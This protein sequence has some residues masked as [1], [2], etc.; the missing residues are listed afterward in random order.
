MIVCVFSSAMVSRVSQQ[1]ALERSAASFAGVLDIHAAVERHLIVA[2]AA[3]VQA[4][5]RVADALDEQLFHVQC[6]YPPTSS[7][8]TVHLPARDI[9]RRLPLT[10]FD[11]SRPR[12][13]AD[14]D[15]LLA[16]HCRVRNTD[17]GDILIGIAACQTVMEEWKCI[18]QPRR[19]SFAKPSAPEFHMCQTFPCGCYNPK[20]RYRRGSKAARSASKS[21]VGALGSPHSAS[22][23]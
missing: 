9:G 16:E 10:S 14:N 7:S 20:R 21:P 12:R 4:L 8:T 22:R 1:F 13:P 5:A 19:S 17:P 11:Q 23:S 18:D 15:P 2:A 6:G 3:R